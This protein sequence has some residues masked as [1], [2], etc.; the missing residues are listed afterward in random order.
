MSPK[1]HPGS[2]YRLTERSQT[3]KPFQEITA[4]HC[5]E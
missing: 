3:T 4:A 1:L 2:R 5:H